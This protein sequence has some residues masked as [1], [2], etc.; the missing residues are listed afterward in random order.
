MNTYRNPLIQDNPAD[1]L[2]NIEQVISLL[3]DYHL[4]S[5]QPDSPQQS[6][7]HSG[8]FWVLQSV[9]QAVKFELARL[10]KY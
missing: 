10:N 6:D 9:N 3:Q 8:L 5:S 7:T 1:T 2:T 4:V